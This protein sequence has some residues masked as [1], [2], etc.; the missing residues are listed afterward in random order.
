MSLIDKFTETAKNENSSIM[1]GRNDKIGKNT[2][3][4]RIVPHKGWLMHED[5]LTNLDNDTV[6]AVILIFNKPG[7]A[8]NLTPQWGVQFIRDLVDQVLTDNANSNPNKDRLNVA[9]VNT[10]RRMDQKW[11]DKYQGDTDRYA[12]RK[13]DADDHKSMARAVTQQDDIAQIAKEI[14]G[15]N[16]YLGIGF[17]Y[18]VSA[19]SIEL[20]DKFVK[21][22]QMS[23]DKRIPGTVVAYPNGNVDLEFQHIFSNPMNEPGMKTMMTSSE[24]AGFYNL[25][26][27]GI[28]DEHGVYVGEQ[29]GD[30]NNTAIIWDMTDFDKYA[31]MGIENRFARKRDYLSHSIPEEYQFFT[32]SDLWLNTLML[33]LVRE[34]QGR[35]FTLALDPVHISSFLSGVTSIIDLNQ[36]VIN[37][38]EAFGSYNDELAIYHSN[39]EKWN[40]MAR[41]LASFLITTKHATQKEPLSQP[42]IDDLD[43]ILENF[44]IDYNMWTINPQQNRRDIHF[45]NVPHNDVPTLNDFLAEIKTEYLRYSDPDT[46]DRIKAEEVNRLYSVFN[47]MQTLASDLFDTHTSPIIDSIGT[48]R[49]TVFDYSGLYK[50]GGNTLLVQLL[51]SISAITNQMVDGD[52]LIIHGAQRITSMTQ[53]YINDILSGLI[54]KHVRIVYSYQRVDDML[55]NSDFNHLSSS[56]WTLTGFLTPDQIT[57]YNKI[58]GNQRQ[59][60]DSVQT[61]IQTKNDS[62]YYL[63]RGPQNILFKANQML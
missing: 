25:V 14:D 28:E 63:R 48:A 10:V 62:Y 15:G 19:S 47:R 2:F 31:V 52:V 5:Y 46:G 22:L 57:E 8:N 29:I 40:I 11:I 9:F 20:M 50:R 56:D 12:M 58:L 21:K 42:E 30:I 3:M 41:Q 53:D 59:M 38:F 61:N 26:T 23:L 16:A 36:G 35:V 43:T 13:S 39:T 7:Q 37:P 17:K 18:I 32:G 60:T 54:T 4:S 34:K 55:K 24:F 51:N 6:N 33:Q 49:N 27:S 44:Y 1:P 45:V